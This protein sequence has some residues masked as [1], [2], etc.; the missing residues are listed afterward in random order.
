[1]SLP[2]TGP[3]AVPWKE[4]S[5]TTVAKEVHPFDPVLL[6]SDWRRLAERILYLGARCQL[7]PS[8]PMMSGACGHLRFADKVPVYLCLRCREGQWRIEGRS[9]KREIAESIVS[10][11]ADSISA[12]WQMA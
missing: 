8:P 5:Q 12:E 10:V 9:P 4:L 6:E 1:H 3:F 7:V 2:G 11:I